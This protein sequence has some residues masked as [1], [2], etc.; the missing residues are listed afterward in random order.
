MSEDIVNRYTSKKRAIRRRF[1]YLNGFICYSQIFDYISSID[2]QF[3][4]NRWYLTLTFFRANLIAIS[5]K[6]NERVGISRCKQWGST[7]SEKGSPN[8]TLLICGERF[9][10]IRFGRLYKFHKIKSG[11]SVSN[12]EPSIF[13]R[14]PS[15]SNAFN[16]HV[17]LSAVKNSG[18]SSMFLNITQLRN[19]WY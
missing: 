18:N 15:T 13:K 4:I 10:D 7:K 16:S 19:V 2:R 3:E 12:K 11:Y 1:N 8:L 17:F 5:T 14:A 9:T 6:R